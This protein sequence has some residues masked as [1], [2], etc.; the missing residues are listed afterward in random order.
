MII[1]CSSDDASP[2]SPRLRRDYG[3][4]SASRACHRGRLGIRSIGAG[5]LTARLAIPADYGERHSS[6]YLSFLMPRKIR[7]TIRF[8][9]AY[10]P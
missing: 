6:H 7:Q 4:T 10:G 3:I 2:P 8:P 1:A 5:R 9:P